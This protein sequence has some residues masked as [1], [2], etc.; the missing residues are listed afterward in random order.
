[1]DYFEVGMWSTYNFIGRWFRVNWPSTFVLHCSTSFSAN[2]N[3]WQKRWTRN[4][5][6]K[7]DGNFPKKTSIGGQ[8][9]DV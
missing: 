8:G 9:L 2:E 7:E 4:L 3:I 5:H 1:M 6:F